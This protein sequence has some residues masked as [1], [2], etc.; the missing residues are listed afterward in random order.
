MSMI[1]AE[2]AA[3]LFH[4]VFARL[5]LAMQSNRMDMDEEYV[6]VYED[7][8]GGRDKKGRPNKLRRY[9]D[10]SYRYAPVTRDAHI[11]LR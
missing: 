2:D 11:T 5:L 10:D 7:D 6:E 8:R 4:E 1:R 9:K 3:P